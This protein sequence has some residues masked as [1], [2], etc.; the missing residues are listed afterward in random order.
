MQIPPQQRTYGV[1]VIYYNSHHSIAENFWVN[2]E[3]RHLYASH[4]Y[5]IQQERKMPKGTS[6]TTH[7]EGRNPLGLG[8]LEAAIYELVLKPPVRTCVTH[9]KVSPLDLRQKLDSL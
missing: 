1:E 8:A 5:R 6:S 4:M 9:S 2:I 7:L 3:H